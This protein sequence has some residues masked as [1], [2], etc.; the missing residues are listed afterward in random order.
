MSDSK[1]LEQVELNMPTDE[2]DKLIEGKRALQRFLFNNG[3][4][5]IVVKQF[6]DE[7]IFT[8]DDGSKVKVEVKDY[9]PVVDSVEDQENPLTDE[10]QGAIDAASKL[11][12]DPKKRGLLGK[13]PKKELEK[14]LGDM[15]NKLATKITDIAS[16]I[17]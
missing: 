2:L 14:A 9:M 17:K 6:R 15:Y 8:L 13:N 5:D 4:K 16:D 11:V 3:V 12:S 1:F 7:I 10:E